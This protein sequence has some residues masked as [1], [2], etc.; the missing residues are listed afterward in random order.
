MLRGQA[1][2]VQHLADHVIAERG[3]RHGCPVTVP[4][5]VKR[6]AQVHGTGRHQHPHIHVRKAG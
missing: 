2:G 5:E 1:H 6:E 4:V 3:V